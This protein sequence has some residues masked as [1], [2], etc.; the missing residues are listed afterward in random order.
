MSHTV[1]I[2][3]TAADAELTWRTDR[4]LAPAADRF[5]DFL[6]NAAPFD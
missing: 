2:A 3:L 4:A 6:R 5:V 1:G